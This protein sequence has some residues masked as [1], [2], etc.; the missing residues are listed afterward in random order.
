MFHPV[1]ELSFDFGHL[2]HHASNNIELKNIQK[3]CSDNRGS[4]GGREHI[5]E[6][7]QKTTVV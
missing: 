5:D 7:D 2:S 4:C 6:D 1:Q 3:K